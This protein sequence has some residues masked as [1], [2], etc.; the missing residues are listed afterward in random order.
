M[1]DAKRETYE[2]GL[3]GI[4]LG[5][6]AVLLGLVLLLVGL[7]GSVLSLLLGCLE[8]GGGGRGLGRRRGHGVRGFRGASGRRNEDCRLFPKGDRECCCS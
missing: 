4:D 5:S 3:E 7:D 6:D 8:G 1:P 2:L